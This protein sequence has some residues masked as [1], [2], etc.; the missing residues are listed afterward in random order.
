[1]TV[2]PIEGEA[3][4]DV[5]K[6]IAFLPSTDL[7]RSRDFFSDLLGLAIV[8]ENPYVCVFQCMS[9]TL[10]VTLVAQFVP[11]AFT[12]FGWEVRDIRS[13]LARLAE[14]GIAAI[15]YQGM[16]QDSD[17]VWTAPGGDLVAWFVDPD[18]N[19]LS[20]TQFIPSTL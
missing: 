11:Q 3:L 14:Q 6:P 5:A 18:G 19:T 12:V 8:D 9:T 20:L 17:G 7:Q 13:V 4:L 1:M 15:R 10:R 2:C 16:S